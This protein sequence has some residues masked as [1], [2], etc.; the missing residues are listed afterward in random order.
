MHSISPGHL[1]NFQFQALMNSAAMVFLY[2]VHFGRHLRVSWLLGHRAYMYAQPLKILSKQF[3][4]VVME[5]K[6]CLRVP[7]AL[8]LLVFVFISILAILVG[9]KYT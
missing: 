3:S 8:Y 6:Q 5:F 2:H 1:C 7:V 4:K 9:V